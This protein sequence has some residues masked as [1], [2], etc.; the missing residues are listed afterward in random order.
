MAYTN[1][2]A[3]AN[4]DA[5]T[6]AR[7]SLLMH[8]IQ[9]FLNDAGELSN[10]YIQKIR[11]GLEPPHYIKTI[12]VRGI[13]NQGIMFT[14]LRFEID[15]NTYKMMIKDGKQTIS[16]NWEDDISPNLRISVYEFNRHCDKLSLNKE[17]V[18][19][20]DS[21]VNSKDA[22]RIL[23]FCDAPHRSWGGKPISSPAGLGPLEEARLVFTVCV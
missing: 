6:N 18:V 14:E 15:W 13:D 23:G 9:V 19:V 2:W 11:K 7:Y 12:S 4:A 17:C 1:T 20:Y 3:K 10:S 21:W 8:Q 5:V 16:P 22:D